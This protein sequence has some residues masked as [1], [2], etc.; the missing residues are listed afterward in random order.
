[1]DTNHPGD[2]FLEFYDGEML[3]VSLKAGGKSTKEPLLN[4]YVNTVYDRFGVSGEYKKLKLE[5]FD[6]VYSSIS[7]DYPEMPDKKTYDN[8]NSK[9]TKNVLNKLA[10]DDIVRYEQGYNQYLQMMR[11]NIVNLFEEEE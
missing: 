10:K 3:G 9:K 8:K 6:A 5:V 1:M 7:N 4:T 2:I 11:S